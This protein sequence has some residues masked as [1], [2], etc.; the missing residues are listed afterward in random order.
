[1]LCDKV[2]QWLVAG[3][4]FSP[5]TPISSSNRTDNHDITEI[6]LK[7]ALNTITLT[8]APLKSITYVKEKMYWCMHSICINYSCSLF[9]Y[10]LS[11]W[12]T[13]YLPLNG[14]PANL[15][16]ISQ[17]KK[18]TIV[19][20]TLVHEFYLNEGVMFSTSCTNCFLF[21]DKKELQRLSSVHSNF[22]KFYLSLAASNSLRVD[23]LRDDYQEEYG[24]EFH[25]SLTSLT[26]KFLSKIDDHLPLTM[27]EKVWFFLYY[28]SESAFSDLLTVFGCV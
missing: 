20:Y 7:V 14:F 10:Q 1:M 18:K 25:S 5:G 11:L 22:R 9:R 2:C 24:P 15:K 23:Y 3:R 19:P 8:L 17:K 16:L 27:F 4:W 13:H 28:Y 26:N 21:Q 6:L 12:W